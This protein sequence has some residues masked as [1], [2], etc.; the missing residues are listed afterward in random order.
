[1]A[2]NSFDITAFQLDA[3]QV[4]CAGT[5]AF[6]AALSS[7]SGEGL[8]IFSGMGALGPL[9]GE[10]GA[11]GELRFSG[12][13][14][15]LTVLSSFSGLA[16]LGFDGEAAFTGRH[17]VFDADARLEFIF[18]GAFQSVI[19][20][21]LT[22]AE[23]RFVSDG[24]FSTL[25]ADF[26][27]DSVLLF[28]GISSFQAESGILSVE[29]TNIVWF[30][31]GE[32]EFINLPT[33]FQALGVRSLPFLSRFAVSRPIAVEEKD[34]LIEFATRQIMRKGFSRDRAKKIVIKT[35][36]KAG[37]LNPKTGQLTAKGEV[38]QAMTPGQ[39][40]FSRVKMDQKDG[41]FFNPNTN[42]VEKR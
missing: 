21:Q 31:T 35:M 15:F 17:T 24:A 25:A 8:L 39:R 2:D 36:I 30:I 10:L 41:Y 20:Q 42:K 4:S 32:G 37:N 38:R 7:E 29:G 28:S 27:A 1:M 34:D 12:G 9:K 5:A 18:S 11:S 26:Y 14:A 6:S 16:S 13:S 33:E 23:L 19:G 22:S 3:F 40:A